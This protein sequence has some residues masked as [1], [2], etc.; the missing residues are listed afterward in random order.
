MDSRQATSSFYGPWASLNGLKVGFFSLNP[1]RPPDNAEPRTISDER[2]KSYQVEQETTKSPITRQFL[3][4]A[5]FLGLKP[6][7]ILT[8]VVAPFRSDSWAELTKKQ[9]DASLEL[10]KRFWSDPLSRP[11]LNLVF[12]CSNEAKDVIT[13]LVD[14]SLDLEISA[15]WGNRKIAGIVPRTR[16]S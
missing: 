5:S 16:R 4:L 8:G 3:L 9:R 12:A 13:E 7:E 10:G 1:G 2:G 15:R 11:E 14:V 6:S